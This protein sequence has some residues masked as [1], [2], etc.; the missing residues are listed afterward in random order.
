MLRIRNQQPE[1]HDSNLEQGDRGEQEQETHNKH[2]D[3]LT[4]SE[5]KTRTYFRYTRVDQQIEHSWAG[6]QTKGG[7]E[8][9]NVTHED[10]SQ[11]KYGTWNVFIH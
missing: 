2:T 10:R 11:L 5:G 8:K 3:K 4:N 1:G 6:K 9:Q 7:N